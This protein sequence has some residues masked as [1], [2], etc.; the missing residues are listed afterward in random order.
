MSKQ[1]EAAM[2]GYQGAGNA[3][4]VFNDDDNPIHITYPDGTIET[5]LYIYDDERVDYKVY[6]HFISKDGE[7]VGIVID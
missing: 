5:R 6:R 3:T 2:Y 7:Y 1:I 4:V